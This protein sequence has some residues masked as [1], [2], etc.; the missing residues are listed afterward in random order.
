MAGSDVSRQKQDVG[1]S[2]KSCPALS[3]IIAEFI[4]FDVEP[5]GGHA[6]AVADEEQGAGMFQLAH[7][8]P[9]GIVR[10]YACRDVDVD[11]VILILKVLC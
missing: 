7:F 10:G 3:V 9:C 1:C 6:A 4:V 2:L 5:F 8:V 11:S